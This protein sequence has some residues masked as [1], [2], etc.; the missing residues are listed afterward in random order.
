MSLD[1]ITSDAL[2]A[3][4]HGFF[5]RAGGASSGVFHGLNCGQGSSDQ[6]QAVAINRSRVAAHFGVPVTQLHTVFQ[7]HSA[8]VHVVTSAQVFEDRPRADAM[9]TDVKGAVLGILTADC[10]PVLFS[11]PDAGIIGAAHAGWRGAMQGILENTILQM[12]KLG[13]HRQS[14][15]AVIGP[16][17]S[18]KN[19]EVGQE[20][21]EEFMDFSAENSRFFVSGNAPQ[22]YQFDLP[23]FGLKLLRDAGVRHA[24]WTRHCTYADP[25]R[26]FSYRRSCHLNEADYGR[27]ISA[28]TL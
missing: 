20:F 27:L 26:F 21:F 24:E 4:R 12:E 8:D 25:K 15:T 16:N 23:A 1:V 11:D 9:V 3:C 22:K 13:A 18:Q 28:V 2:R 14:I 5:A 19:Y 10:Q 7:Q 17:I 6:S